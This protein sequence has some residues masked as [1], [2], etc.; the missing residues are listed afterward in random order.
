[1]QPV[2]GVLELG[3]LL[4]Q[5]DARRQ[6]GD[7]LALHEL[8]E[9]P[10]RVVLGAQPLD[11]LA[12]AGEVLELAALHRLTDLHVHPRLLLLDARAGRGAAGRPVGVALLRHLLQRSHA[13]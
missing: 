2:E 8:L 4:A 9:P 5:C 1:V 6:H 10:V 11:G 12:V 13:G 3:V 7:V